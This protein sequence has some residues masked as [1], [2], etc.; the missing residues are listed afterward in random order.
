MKKGM[1][2]IGTSV[3]ILEWGNSTKYA[4]ITPAIAP[5]APMAGIDEPALKRK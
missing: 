4:P 5:D 2:K 3:I 1:I